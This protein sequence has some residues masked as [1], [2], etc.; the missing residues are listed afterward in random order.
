[1]EELRANEALTVPA[2]WRKKLAVESDGASGL[3][4]ADE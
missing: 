2:G 1:V 3:F 4:L